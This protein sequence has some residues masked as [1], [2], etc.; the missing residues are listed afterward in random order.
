M[1]IKLSKG[2]QVVEKILE[3]GPVNVNDRNFRADR[4]QCF[5]IHCIARTVEFKVTVN[6]DVFKELD[7]ENI[8]IDCCASEMRAG[9]YC[10]QKRQYKEKDITMFLSSLVFQGAAD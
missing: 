8:A 3:L 10:L 2:M 4:R 7:N 6:L 5:P 1:H 9:V